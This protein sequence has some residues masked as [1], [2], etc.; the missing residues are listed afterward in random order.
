MSLQCVSLF[1]I[2]NETHREEEWTGGIFHN[3]PFGSPAYLG[4]KKK[5]GKECAHA[6]VCASGGVSEREGWEE[7]RVGG[8]GNAME[9]PRC[10]SCVAV[11]CFLEQEKWA[12]VTVM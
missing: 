9:R 7:E 4:F 10:V 11:Y 5:G 2:T 1:I 8:G 3:L 6:C 12:Y